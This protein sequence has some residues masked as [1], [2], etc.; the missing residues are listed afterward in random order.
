MLTAVLVRWTGVPP[1]SSA[2]PEP[3]IKSTI[4]IASTN[5]HHGEDVCKAQLCRAKPREC[6]HGMRLSR[7]RLLETVM[8]N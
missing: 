5:L 3:P 8:L 4:R 1:R 6:G 2:K 7:T